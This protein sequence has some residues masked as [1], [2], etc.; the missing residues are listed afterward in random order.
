MFL[1][2]SP[3]VIG[4]AGAAT[5]VG[6][7]LAGRW[8]L[9]P[10]LGDR[11]PYTLVIVAVA[12][13]ARLCG[14]GPAL[15][16]LAAGCPAALW[17]FV[18]PR[19]TFVMP[20][21][22]DWC[23][24]A[25]AAGGGGL[26]AWLIDRLTRQRDALA[27]AA[28]ALTEKEQ[29]LRRLVEVQESE[30]QTL[31]HDIHDG[32]LQEV[33]GAQMLLEGGRG[34]PGSVDTAVAALRRGVA[35]GRR[36]IRGIRTAVLD[37]LGI[38]AAISDLKDQMAE[39]G[40]AVDVAVGSAVAEL[41]ASLQ[42]TIYRIVQESLTNVRKHSGADRARVEVSR[43]NGE[44]LVCVQDPGRGCDLQAA[45]QQ[46]FGILGMGERVRLA[47][48]TFS[49]HCAPAVGTRVEARLPCVPLPRG[50]IAP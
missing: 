49:I 13:A 44:L 25:G 2:G 3:R 27:R 21:F 18:E 1:R 29:I 39:A 16:C 40:I 41:P 20:L 48:G 50:G 33:L 10:L 5:L 34:D 11:Q 32:L 6:C 36:A 15:L 26:I 35:E 4:Y 8:L 23:A 47:G 17:L 7:A 31:C 46:G 24:L 19:G 14:L 45:R 37:D 9:D 42:T 38:V 12:V 28:S 43:A 22:G 30:K